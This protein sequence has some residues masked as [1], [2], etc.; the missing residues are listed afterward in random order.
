MCI[1]WNEGLVWT[2]H[3][4]YPLG[5]H[6]NSLTT[7]YATCSNLWF[8][9]LHLLYLLT[10]LTQS[11]KPIE[12]NK[13]SVKQITSILQELFV[14][15]CDIHVTSEF[16]VSMKNMALTEIDKRLE[17]I[18][19]KGSGCRIIGSNTGSII[20][21]SQPMRLCSHLHFWSQSNNHLQ[22]ESSPW[23]PKSPCPIYPLP[24]SKN[25]LYPLI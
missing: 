24:L 2:C 4:T 7:I 11:I 8:E 14:P 3:M 15:S 18:Q 1:S 19:P 5:F 16:S 21:F 23:C 13:S 17:T 12:W 6:S 9:V 22:F 20:Q 10:S 25:G